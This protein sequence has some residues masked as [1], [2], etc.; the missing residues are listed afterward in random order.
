MRSALREFR[1]GLCRKS[2]LSAKGAEYESQ[3]Q[4]RSESERVAPGSKEIIEGSTESATYQCQLF[5]SFRAL[6]S[7]ALLPGTT[8]LTLFGACPWLSY[9]APSALRPNFL[10]KVSVR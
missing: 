2:A 3:G 1:E 6:R 9:S 10:C 7:C 4:A 8:R 5:R